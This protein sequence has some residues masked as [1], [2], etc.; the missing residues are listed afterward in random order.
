MLKVFIGY[1]IRQPVAFQVL[2]HS[3]WKRASQP[4]EIVRLDIRQLPIKRTGL[5]EF[6]YSRY[7][8]PYLMDY[9]GEALFLDSDM[10]CLTDICE[11][12]E[13]ARQNK[14]PLSVVKGKEQFE[15]PSLMYFN[16]PKC[17]RLVPSFIENQSPQKWV[18]ENAGELPARF[19]H[20]IPYD[21]LNPDAK[22]VHFTQGIPCFP[23]TK[24]SE[25]GELW[26]HEAQECM[27][28]VTWETLMGNSV[29]KQRMKG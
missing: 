24:D 17:W 18:F 1:D 2:A 9:Q 19:N 13:I 22:I 28:T 21:G 8:V 7:Y 26:R 5:T 10:L 16:N 25:Y 6:T 20:I 14:E 3:I 12:F 23:E 4:V 29:H 15:W 11:L 27:S